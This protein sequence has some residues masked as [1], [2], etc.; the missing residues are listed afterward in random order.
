MMPTWTN[1][2]KR[3]RTDVPRRTPSSYKRS[4]LSPC[5]TSRI[6]LNLL[7][8]KR[9]YRPL[10]ARLLTEPLKEDQLLGFEV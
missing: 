1:T 10:R 6:D 2:L 8:P 3:L 4:C 7:Y 9:R 5:R